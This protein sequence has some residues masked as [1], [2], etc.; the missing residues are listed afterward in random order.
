MILIPLIQELRSQ[1]R[2][3]MNKITI[4]IVEDD[5]AIAGRELSEA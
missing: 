1:E 4:S 2:V 3:F 5:E